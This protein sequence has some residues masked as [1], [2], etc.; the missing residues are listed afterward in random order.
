MRI[1]DW[2][3]D[4]CSSDLVLNR[5]LAEDDVR[6]RGWGLVHI[7]LGDD[8]QNVLRL[9]DGHADDVWHLAHAQLLHGLAALLLAA[10]LASTAQA[11]ALHTPTQPS[12]P[13][14]H[15]H[16]LFEQTSST[17]CAHSTHNTRSAPRH[18]QH[19]QLRPRRR[20]RRPQPGIQPTN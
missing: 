1:S 7:W 9:L 3:S 19:R 11:L 16:A 18:P 13:Q 20:C 17:A 12:N 6:V 10:A 4:V 5:G 14:R 15:N 8:K 2:S